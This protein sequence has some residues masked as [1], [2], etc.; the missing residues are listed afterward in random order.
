MTDPVLPHDLVELSAEFWRWR[1]ATV[2]DT[3][4]DVVRLDRPHGWLP[5]WSAKAVAERHA[6]LDRF[7]HRLKELP[8]PRTTAEEVDQRLLGCALARVGW[9]LRSLRAWQVS[10]YFYVEQALGPL[11]TF[12]LIRRPFDDDRA[13]HVIRLLDCVPR[14]LAQA[15][16]NLPGH[17]AGPF[18]RYAVRML[19]SIE[20]QMAEVIAGLAAVLPTG[21]VPAFRAA[22][23]AATRAL[24][25]YRGWLRTTPPT[26]TETTAVGPAAFASFLHG[27]S[28]W[29]H[30]VEQLR[31]MA[32]QEWHRAVATETILRHR[33]RDLPPD[34]LFPSAAAEV[35]QQ[36]GDE[37]E[38]RRFYHERNLLSQPETLRHYRFVE[39]PSYLAPLAW[40]G[41]P[42]D[43]TSLAR[44]GED[45]LRYVREPAPDLPYFEL[46]K[47]TDPRTS[48]VHEGVH[49]QQFALSWQHPDPVRR[50]RF[51]SLP[52]EGIA[53]Y[54]EELMLLSGLFDDRPHSALFLVNSMRLRALRAGID[55]D[56]A[57]GAITLDQAADKLARLVPLDQ[58]T[59]WEDAVLYASNPGVGLSYLAG[60]A[61]ILDL[62]TA[63]TQHHG[64]DFDLRAF[65]DRLWRA[66]NVP[67]TLQ[68]LE[69]LGLRDHLDNAD[70][71]GGG[72]SAR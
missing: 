25:D 16:A 68:R 31:V 32:A 37:L 27:V 28:L 55:I 14:T 69:L 62:F 67:L 39:M 63:C 70:K 48:I 23:A 9:E 33:Y 19:G 18:T 71:L 44:A 58:Y 54:N 30:P 15:R 41:V 13:G 53:F 4:D 22:A 36:H 66:G 20:D 43:P 1:A 11:Y 26:V 52:S 46:A 8:P 35:A 29:P 10:P 47:A 34:A 24:V 60:R 51:D 17:A 6:A 72:P 49:A 50:H 45:A 12:L 38:M 61:Q 56:L 3:H 42:H 40:L 59:A 7:S 57:T 2:A 5:D 65:H 21:H 64:P